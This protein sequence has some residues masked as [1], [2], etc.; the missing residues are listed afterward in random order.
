MGAD[1]VASWMEACLARPS[2][3]RTDPSKE[4]LISGGW[5]CYVCVCT[6]DL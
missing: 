6:L 3:A 5:L 2:A 1:R 4:E